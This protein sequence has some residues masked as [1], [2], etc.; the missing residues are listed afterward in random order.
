MNIM[1]LSKPDNGQGPNPM[2]TTSGT[3]QA[4]SQAQG[5][6]KLSTSSTGMGVN[7]NPGFA[8]PPTQ[9]Q[10]QNLA[11]TN[12]KPATPYAQAGNPILQAP[13]A[14]P[15]SPTAYPQDQQGQQQYQNAITQHNQ[16]NPQNP[17]APP[18]LKTQQPVQSS[19]GQSTT[20]PQSVVD[21]G[22]AGANQQIA[23]TQT[24]A[25]NFQD[26]SKTLENAN[27]AAQGSLQDETVQAAQSQY[28]AEQGNLNQFATQAAQSKDALN[29]A[30]E[31]TDTAER[32]DA[33]DQYNNDMIALK[34]QQANT[35]ETYNTQIAEQQTQDQQ[36]V[37]QEESRIAA[38]G[39]YGNL[40]SMREMQFTYQQNNLAMNQLVMNKDNADQNIT[41]QILQ[42]N[43]SYNDNL[44]TIEVTKQS[45][46]ADNYAKYTDYVQTVMQDKNK[47]EDDKYTAIK[48]A[49]QD[50]TTNVAKVHGDALTARHDASVASTTE[51]DRLR[52]ETIANQRAN[53][54]LSTF[55]DNQGNV[56][57]VATDIRTGKMLSQ[58]ALGAIGAG[59]LPTA[60]VDPYTGIGYIFDPATKK[61]TML[62]NDINTQSY[63]NSDVPTG[64]NS[65]GGALVS[66]DDL[67]NIFNIGGKGLKGNKS[68]NNGQCG[69]TYNT[70][71]DGPK[72]GDTWDSK[73]KATSIR[74]TEAD[75]T[76]LDIKPGMGLALPL[77]V[78][79]DGT[80]TGH[81][82]TV[83]D[84]NPQTGIMHTIES[85]LD[86]KGTTQTQTRNITQLEQMYKNKDG[87]SNFGFIPSTFT[88]GIQSQL[89]S[90]TVP[91][92]TPN[93]PNPNGTDVTGTNSNAIAGLDS[94]TQ[95]AIK[96]IVSGQFTM[97]NYPFASPGQKYLATQNIT[98]YAPNYNVT[99]A[100]AQAAARTTALQAPAQTAASLYQTASANLQTLQTAENSADKS[101]DDVSTLHSKIPSGGGPFAFLNGLDQQFAAGV[102]DPN[103]SA[104]SSAYRD[105]ITQAGYVI[106]NGNVVTEATGQ[107]LDA[108]VA[109]SLD[110][111]AFITAKN[112]LKGIMHN[113]V[114][115]AQQAVDTAKNDLVSGGTDATSLT[116]PNNPQPT[117]S[118]N[119]QYAAYRTQLQP[120]EILVQNKQGQIGRIPKGEFDSSQYTQ[121]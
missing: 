84:Y 50:Y 114:V 71:T 18:P 10:Q 11:A 109:A 21:T 31:S 22:D 120:G 75:G 25:N 117:S 28:T 48:Q 7:P 40:T 77:L 65:V 41:A 70:I 73:F 94:G 99:T 101:L 112:A 42:T 96:Q 121:L 64:F 54:Q 47:S 108:S 80:G 89:D 36:G 19:T 20:P 67:K 76:N 74:P 12:Q 104:F 46:I 86:G 8:A 102:S 63:L 9:Q 16:T 1:D 118:Q 37:I 59:A 72:V 32:A 119:D 79:T 26:Q 52:Q 68:A 93:Q 69:N 29:A 60:Q 111:K 14:T 82:E 78:K 91:Y 103:L 61:V 35:D 2:Q 44:N 81:M 115:A 24:I 106:T 88:K 83:L 62:G 55:T 5:L 39:G 30:A 113:K 43:K 90:A 105:A 4:L 58:T 23:T 15:P 107:A 49:A 53:V 33:Q 6:P 98:K 3:G 66:N 85:N 57:Q 51:V 100:A 17:V 27:V 56:T 92:P 116:Q 34:F 95:Q 97:D 45:T 110:Q 87:T 38:L 13:S